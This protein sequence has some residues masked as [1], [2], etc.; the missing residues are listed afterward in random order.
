M[1]V[2]ALID[3]VADLVVASTGRILGRRSHLKLVVLPAR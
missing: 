3:L 2:A 1:L